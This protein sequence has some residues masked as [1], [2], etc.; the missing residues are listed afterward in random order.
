MFSGCR[1]CLPSSS[2]SNSHV[3]PSDIASSCPAL[4]AQVTFPSLSPGRRMESPLMPAW[5]WPSTTSTSPAPCGSPTSSECTTA[6]TPASPKTM[7]PSSNTRV[8]SLLEVRLNVKH[9]IL[10]FNKNLLQRQNL[11]VNLWGFCS[12]T[13]VQSAASRPGWNLR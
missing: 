11:N 4:C 12:S 1:Q 5:G 6:P 2:L 13:K 9:P 7:P 8:S 10:D 3:I